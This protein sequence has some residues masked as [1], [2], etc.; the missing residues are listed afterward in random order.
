MIIH[1]EAVATDLM[2][3]LVQLMNVDGLSDFRLVGGTALAL[4][5]GHRKSVDIDLFAG[6]KVDVSKLQPII[7]QNFGNDFVLIT[8]MQNGISG[9]I[10]NV[11]LDL[12]DWKVPFA[13]EAVLLDGIRLASPKDIFA[14]KCESII[15][16][17]SEKD[18]SDMAMLMQHFDLKDLLETF[19]KRYPYI[20]SGAVFPFLLKREVIVRDTTIQYLNGNT[21]EK[22]FEVVQ[23]KL[24]QYEQQAQNKKK[25]GEEERL[26]RIQALI[27]E[28]KSKE[29]KQP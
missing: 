23:Q 1:K 3:V 19:R 4:Q 9:L 21:F 13:E 27:V 24:L 29:R 2:E 18:F 5:F 11:K 15:D 14:Y 20:S 28:K 8:K 7:H 16:R 26:I 17:K 25:Q 10:R 22:Y 6:G 12:F